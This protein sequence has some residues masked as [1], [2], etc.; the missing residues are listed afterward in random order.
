MK[1]DELLL[2]LISLAGDEEKLYDRIKNYPEN[3][4]DNKVFFEKLEELI[5]AL[6]SEY[7]SSDEKTKLSIQ[8]ENLKYFIESM[9][10]TSLKVYKTFEVIRHADVEKADLV[11]TD[12]FKQYVL[13]HCANV[14]NIEKLPP[15]Y[16]EIFQTK[17]TINNFISVYNL[18]VYQCVSKLMSIEAIKECVEYNTKIDKVLISTIAM[19]IDSNFQNLQIN[20]LVMT[21][22]RGR[23]A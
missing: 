10:D 5:A 13:R 21:L 2:E 23:N 4:S 11:V 18:L 15:Y 3:R 12:A 17:D 6:Y 22:S 14:D 20:Y 8:N 7:V 19:L 1:P 9:L 16:H